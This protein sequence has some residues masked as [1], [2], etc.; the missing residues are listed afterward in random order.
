MLSRNIPAATS[1]LATN[2]AY[3]AYPD[4]SYDLAPVEFEKIFWHALPQKSNDPAPRILSQS[5]ADPA[6]E[7]AF[8]NQID[9]FKL[10]Q[11]ESIP[12]CTSVECKKDTAS[13]LDYQD[14]I[15]AHSSYQDAGI[16][17]KVIDA[18]DGST[19]IQTGSVPACTSLGCKKDTMAKPPRD[20]NPTTD[21]WGKM[22]SDW[23]ISHAKNTAELIQLDSS[24]IPTCTS[25]ECFTGTAA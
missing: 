9:S 4:E 7:D 6:W 14:V 25:F 24:S 16:V 8:P 23:G 10:S 3:Y 11:L 17:N 2:N 18:F 20:T 5:A 21:N 22:D 1:L 19:L 12:A 15:T 13:Y